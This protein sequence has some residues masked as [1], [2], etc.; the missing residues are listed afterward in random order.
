MSK[1]DP[2]AVKAAVKQVRAEM[3]RREEAAA[4]EAERKQ[5][6]GLGRILKGKK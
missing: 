5:A 1:D 6:K 4:R 2:K 3:R